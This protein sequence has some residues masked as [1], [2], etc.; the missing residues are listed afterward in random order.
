MFRHGLKARYSFSLNTAIGFVVARASSPCVCDAQT[1]ARQ[2][3]GLAAR[4]TQ[5]AIAEFGF[6]P[7]E[8]TPTGFHPPAQGCLS[9]RGLPWDLTTNNHQPQRGCVLRFVSSGRNPVGVVDYCHRFPRVALADSVNPGLWDATPLALMMRP[10]IEKCESRH[11]QKCPCLP[12][13]NRGRRSE[14]HI[15]VS[16]VIIIICKIIAS[17]RKSTA[18]NNMQSYVVIFVCL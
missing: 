18:I 5:S 16:S 15:I 9:L 1:S 6:A 8:R 7:R 11:R 14:L 12:D 4:A 13:S 2:T 10:H 17:N 3:H